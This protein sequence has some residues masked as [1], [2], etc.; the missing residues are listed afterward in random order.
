MNCQFC[1]QERQK[2]HLS[3]NT[4]YWRC[5]ACNVFYEWNKESLLIKIRF[6]FYI[7]KSN[8]EIVIHP[9]APK[10]YFIYWEPYKG[11]VFNGVEPDIPVILADYDE[12][13]N[14]TPE[15]ALNKLK[16]VLMFQ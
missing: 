15:N 5:K 2:H 8:Y 1:K 7:N 6:N 4:S 12:A 14:I 13:L 9:L 3:V 11:H 16:M 10:T